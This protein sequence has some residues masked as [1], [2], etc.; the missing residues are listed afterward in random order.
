ML[1]PLGSQ[2]MIRFNHLHPPFDNPKMR[3]GRRCTPFNQED[4]LRG[5][6]RRSGI[7]QGLRRHLPLRHAVRHRCGA[8]DASSRPNSRRPRRCCKEAGY[9]GEPIVLMQPTDL[10]HAARPWRWSRRRRCARPASRSTCRRWT[11]AQLSR[12]RVKKDPADKGGWNIFHTCWSAADIAQ[13]AGQRP[14]AAATATRRGSA[15]RPTRRWRSCATPC[16]GDRSGE[17]EEARRP[18]QIARLK[19]ARSP[20]RPVLRAGRLSRE[21]HRLDQVAGAVLV[22]HRKKRADGRSLPWWALPRMIASPY[23][24]SATAGTRRRR[25]QNATLASPLRRREREGACRAE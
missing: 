22:E 15:G 6:R 3:A 7:L 21:R 2:G 14:N 5:R 23:R 13:S 18:V 19:S 10:P 11:G 16:Q 25:D 8:D 24:H 12:A 20:D 17:A 9:D 4:Y 1:E